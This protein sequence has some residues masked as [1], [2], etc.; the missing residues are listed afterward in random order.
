[1][2]RYTRGRNDR[3]KLRRGQERQKRYKR[4]REDEQGGQRVDGKD[5]GLNEAVRCGMLKGDL[6]CTAGKEVLGGGGL[7]QD[8]QR[9]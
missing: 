9:L 3:G 8:D 7:Q 2:R 6:S 5:K 1:M 4:G